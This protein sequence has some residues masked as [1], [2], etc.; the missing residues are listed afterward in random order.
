L[1]AALP[2]G[3]VTTWL[4]PQAGSSFPLLPYAGFVLSGVWIGALVL[5]QGTATPAPRVAARLTGVALLLAAL[6][7]ASMPLSAAALPG[8]HTP[9]FFALKLALVVLACAALS[10]ALRP[11][12]GLPPLLA[13]LTGETLGIYVFHLFV[14]YGAPLALA[15]RLGT[16]LSLPAALG[17]SGLLLL[18]S[19]LFALGWRRAKALPLAQHKWPWFRTR[20]LALA[21]LWA[22]CLAWPPPARADTRVPRTDRHVL[23]YP[24]SA[25]RQ[26]AQ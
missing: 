5:P 25:H 3:A 6:S 11:V 13:T 9:A 21:S 20:A 14:L 10:L 23:G 17:C 19:A 16:S 15:R 26:R 22:M 12:R 7:A 4:G 2:L 1:P 8:V 24:G 18:S